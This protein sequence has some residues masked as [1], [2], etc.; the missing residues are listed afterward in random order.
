MFILLGC[1]GVKMKPDIRA[2][3]AA[4]RAWMAA[5]PTAPAEQYERAMRLLAKRYRI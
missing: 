3:E 2:Y 1:I 5:H 4:K